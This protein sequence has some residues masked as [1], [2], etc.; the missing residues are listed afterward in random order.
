MALFSVLV[1][2]CAPISE[3][4]QI[5]VSKWI[6]D[7]P[8]VTE[9]FVVFLTSEGVA[10]LSPEYGLGVYLCRTNEGQWSYVGHLLKHSASAIMTLPTEFVPIS[11]AVSVTIGITVE[12]KSVLDNLGTTTG[13]NQLQYRTASRLQI[14]QRIGNH[15]LNFILSYS[16]TIPFDV[17]R[18]LFPNNPFAG[19]RRIAVEGEEDAGISGDGPMQEIVIVPNNWMSEWWKKLTTAMTKDVAFWKESDG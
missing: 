5:E 15:L 8:G 2:G 19:A 11:G 13:Q 17:Y 4:V 10:Q 1:P 12:P 14:A 18:S 9:Q 16:R 3:F 7:L 6:V